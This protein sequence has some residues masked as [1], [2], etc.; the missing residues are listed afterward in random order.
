MTESTCLQLIIGLS[1]TECDCLTDQLPSEN[2]NYKESKSGLYL[3]ELDGFNINKIAGAADCAK[4]GIW[5]IMDR[6]R[7]TAIQDYYTNLL[8]C[9]GAS[10]KPRITSFQSQL[11]E[12]TFKKTLTNSFGDYAGMRI[13]PAQIKGAYIILNKIGVIINEVANV[14][15]KVFSNENGGTL[16]LTSAPIITQANAITWG[17]LTDPLEL[18]MWSINNE[19]IR[20]YIVMEMNGTFKPKDNKKDCGCSSKSKPYDKWIALDGVDGSDTENMNSFRVNS[21]YLNGIIAQVEVKCDTK[22]VVCS[23]VYPPDYENDPNMINAAVAIRFRAAARCYEEL[24]SSELINR[25]TMMNREEIRRYI[26]LWNTEFQN[27]IKYLCENFNPEV[28]ECL[29]CRTTNRSLTKST[30]LK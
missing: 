26:D 6:A 22:E 7:N 9:I 23:D 1:Q 27:W 11:G 29:I 16:I 14:V 13:S 30:I 18:P 25:T 28:N 24:L 21:T 10:Y 19:F 15:L 20:Y 4:G 2:F 12:A 17:T 5:E 3:D 8:G